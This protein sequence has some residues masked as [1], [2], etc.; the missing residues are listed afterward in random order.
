MLLF[1][2]EIKN[3]FVHNN[4]F[5]LLFYQCLALRLENIFEKI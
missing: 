1:W 4:D 3:S 5:D 2:F